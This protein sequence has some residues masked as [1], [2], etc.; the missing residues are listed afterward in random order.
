MSPHSCPRTRLLTRTLAEV[1]ELKSE[2][3]QL[4]EANK[5]L[6]LYVS[7]IVDRVCS[8]EGFEKVLAVDYRLATPKTGASPDPTTKP[9]YNPAQPPAT[10]FR[11]STYTLS[12][13][14]RAASNPPPP[15][16]V[17]GRRILGWDALSSVFS[18]GAPRQPAASTVTS[19][20]LSA[21]TS[22]LKPFVLG[23]DPS[24][25][26]LETEEDEDDLRERERLKAEM[27]LHG[28]QD[29]GNS[30]GSGR[31]S[32]SLPPTPDPASVSPT[33]AGPPVDLD[34]L[35]KSSPVAAQQIR[36]TIEKEKAAKVELEQGRASGF[37][38][39]KPRR[40]RPGSMRSSRSSSSRGEGSVGLG[41]SSD[42]PGGTG[43]ITP[44][45]SQ[46]VSSSPASG[47]PEA[48]TK[49]DPDETDASWS[50][51]LK[52]ISLSLGR[53]PI[54]PQLAPPSGPTTPSA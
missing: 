28:L 38:E 42:A 3:K 32:M 19:P 9:G 43:R 5:A 34:E 25:R 4:K 21:S 27:A 6:T 12:P 29:S 1:F 31:N 53:G 16:T 10:T 39:T 40:Q 49:A 11:N 48:A 45:G 18:G 14:E 22:G 41:I 47:S 7:K 23:S 8:Q 17:T 30:W 54:S 51:R 37:T 50:K 20:N 52:R 36:A 15:S 44:D 2:L 13:R 26:K 33:P 24:A 35:Y 46:G